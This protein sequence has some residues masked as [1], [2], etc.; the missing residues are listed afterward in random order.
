MNLMEFGIRVYPYCGTQLSFPNRYYLPDCTEMWRTNIAAFQQ[1]WF[2]IHAAQLGF[3]GTAK[4][5]AYQAVYDRT[6][7]RAQ[8]HWLIGPGSEGFPLM[9]SYY[10]MSL[11][12]HTTE[13][14][15]QVIGVDP[16]DPS[17]WTAPAASGGDAADD[18]PEKE[19]TAFAGAGQLTLLGLDT[20]GKALNT[21]STEDA[22]YSIGGLP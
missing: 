14:G 9:P 18:T 3:T 1:L 19:M 5:D 11:L 7:V 13:P 22:A 16:W 15:W 21:V 10:A 20:N 17:D 12:F 8:L 2:N 4:W 6:S